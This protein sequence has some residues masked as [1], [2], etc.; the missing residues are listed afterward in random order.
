MKPAAPY[1]EQEHTGDE[2]E[3][4]VAAQPHQGEDSQRQQGHGHDHDLGCGRDM[5]PHQLRI[6]HEQEQNDRLCCVAGLQHAAQQ[7]AG[8]YML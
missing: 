3:Q 2:L 8:R 4:R 1:P 5:E 7:L 6:T